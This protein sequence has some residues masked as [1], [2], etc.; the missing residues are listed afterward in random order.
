MTPWPRHAVVGDVC[1]TRPLTLA[2]GLLSG[3]LTGGLHLVSDS[4]EHLVRAGLC[5]TVGSQLR[6]AERCTCGGNEQG[7]HTDKG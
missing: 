3:G 2:C 4:G 7:V 5:H 1:M 6:S